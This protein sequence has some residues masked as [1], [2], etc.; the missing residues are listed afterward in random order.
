MS[1]G[2]VVMDLSS[3]V[4]LGMAASAEGFLYW[5]RWGGGFF[6]I[7][8]LARYVSWDKVMIVCSCN[9]FSDQQ[10]RS[11]LAK[12][13]QRLRMSQI[14][15]L[16]RQQRAVRSLHPR[17]QTDYGASSRPRDRFCSS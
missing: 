3:P 7:S 1:G 11:T 6:F 17:H 10:L 5:H 8:A 13:T 2:G 12:A 4:G 9:V 16:S 14:Y 15:L